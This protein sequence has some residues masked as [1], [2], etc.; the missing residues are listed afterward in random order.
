MTPDEEERI[1]AE[2][3][4]RLADARAVR[5]LTRAELSERSGVSMPQLGRIERGG[6]AHCGLATIVAIARALDVDAG[7][8]GMGS[9]QAAPE[10]VKQRLRRTRR[11]GYES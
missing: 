3:A 6:G 4:D 7:W 1:G 10:W 2:L 11:R 5:G 8:L 9:P